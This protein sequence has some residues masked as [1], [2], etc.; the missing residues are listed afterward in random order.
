MTQSPPCSRIRD[1]L[2]TSSPKTEPGPV[3][4]ADG[5]QMTTSTRGGTVWLLELS[6]EITDRIDAAPIAELGAEYLV[7]DLEEVERITSYGIREWIKLLGGLEAEYYCFVRSPPPL[8]AQFNMVYDFRGEGEI[9]SLFLPYLCPACG[10]ETSHL[11][12]LR[13]E[14]GELS[15]Y[16]PPKLDCPECGEEANF[17]DIPEL[18]LECLTRQG[19]PDVPAEVESV[20]DDDPNQSGETSTQNSAGPFRIRKE[21]VGGVTALWG[22][23]R[24]DSR[25]RIDRFV[26]GLEEPVL[27]VCSE[28]SEVESGA[29]RALIEE[30]GVEFLLARVEPHHLERLVEDEEFR[31]R[32]APVTTETRVECTSCEWGAEQEM[33][34]ASI[35]DSEIPDGPQGCPR[36]FGDLETD[37]PE[38]VRG[39]YRRFE[40]PP[41]G[42]EV[43]GYLALRDSGSRA[44]ASDK[45][46]TVVGQTFGAYTLEEKIG[47]G[48]MADIYLARQSGPEDFRRKVVVKELRLEAGA[49]PDSIDSFKQEA[50]FAARLSHPNIVQVTDFG[51]T[52]QFYYLVME[53]VDGADLG[54]VLSR[55]RSLRI[56]M[57]VEYA[58]HIAVRICDALH[59]AHSMMDV[60]GE[61]DPVVHRDVSPHNILV[62]RHGVPKLTDFGIARLARDLQGESTN[63]IRGKV[64]YL[65]PEMID[66]KLGP[67]DA[68][69]DV[70]SLGTVLYESLSGETLFRRESR[71]ETMRAVVTSAPSALTEFRSDVP[72]EL[73][74]VVQKAVAKR[75]EDRFQSAREFQRSLEEI[76]QSLG[77]VRERELGEWVGELTGPRGRGPEETP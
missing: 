17:D 60:G 47:S 20:L 67:V 41:P 55:I 13:D 18:Y 1:D 71:E 14:Y 36:C 16:D 28:I 77:V 3:E 25:A 15:D 76:L 33:E 73:D 26:Q 30:A 5:L 43:R 21:V 31:E 23:G 62:S 65:A 54:E 12:D 72:E 2:M 46:E 37:L 58:T 19:P 75:P 66:K 29:F 49:A 61:P 35:V 6:G 53:Y 45:F 48:G 44:R 7:F 38:E 34:L 9:V 70:F 68:R 64:G 51:R 22:S 24:L 27:L 40:P 42:D 11:A 57:P 50:R 32:V 69:S 74:G 39:L 4:I 8:V 52:D 10:A 63:A 56:R 59:A